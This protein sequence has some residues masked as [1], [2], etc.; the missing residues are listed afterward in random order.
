MYHLATLKG[1][2]SQ[3]RTELQSAKEKTLGA[4]SSSSEGVQ[5]LGGGTLQSVL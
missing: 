2:I 5:S 4:D 1:N 3:V